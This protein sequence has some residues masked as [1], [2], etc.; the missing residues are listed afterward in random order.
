MYGYLHSKAEQVSVHLAEMDSLIKEYYSL[1]VPVQE[2]VSTM[3]C[4]SALLPNYFK[5]CSVM[6]GLASEHGVSLV[7]SKSWLHRVLDVYLTWTPKIQD[8]LEKQIKLAKIVF[9]F[10]E[11]VEEPGGDDLKE[12]AVLLR[13]YL[14]SLNT[15]DIKEIGQYRSTLYAQL[16]ALFGSSF[17]LVQML[18]YVD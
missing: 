14:A 7:P 12:V 10:N 3:N 15:D 8:L 13:S 18:P 6:H 16:H 9:Y 17:T 4:Q 2:L 11:G 1:P 5:L